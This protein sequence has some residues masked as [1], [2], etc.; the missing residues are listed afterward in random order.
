[1]AYPHPVPAL[2]GKAARELAEELEKARAAK[3]RNPRWKGSRQT[4]EK[5]RPKGGQD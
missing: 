2:K 1:M 5:L 4:F 3:R